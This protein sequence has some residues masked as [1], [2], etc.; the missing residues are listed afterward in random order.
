MAEVIRAV[1]VGAAIALQGC[2]SVALTAGGIAG[3]AG[4]NHTLTGIAYKTFTAPVKDLRRATLGT[5]RRMEIKVTRDAVAE[6]GWRIE[7]EAYDRTIEIDLERLTPAT[8]RMRVVTNQGTIF[9]DSAT[10]TEIIIQTAQ[11]LDRAN[12]RAR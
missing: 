8:T 2:A 5:L 11:R 10:S 6:I 3:S 9:K 1:T 4:V 7:G 12:A